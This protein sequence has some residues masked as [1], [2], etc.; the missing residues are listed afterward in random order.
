VWGRCRRWYRYGRR[1]RRAFLAYA[2]LGTL[3]AL[4]LAV[5]IGAVVYGLQGRTPEP[6][7]D[8]PRFQVRWH[9]HGLSWS[10]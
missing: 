10:R 5:V 2:V 8:D 1:Q 6:V 3:G 9:A 4:I 7:G